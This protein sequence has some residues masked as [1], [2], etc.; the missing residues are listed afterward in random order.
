LRYDLAK[1][2]VIILYGPEDQ[3]ISTI[4]VSRKVDLDCKYGRPGRGEGYAAGVFAVLYNSIWNRQVKITEYSVDRI[5]SFD[6]DRDFFAHSTG[7]D[8][9]GGIR[10]FHKRLQKTNIG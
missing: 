10:Y 3:P 9:L 6:V 1:Y 5:F 8:T 2:T 4:S 7:K